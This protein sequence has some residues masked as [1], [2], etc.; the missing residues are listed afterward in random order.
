MKTAM[1]KFGKLA[2]VITLVLIVLLGGCWRQ[3]NR[4]SRNLSLEADN[5]NVARKLTVVNA[6]AED[7]NEAV[8]F[9]MMGNF[10]IN[11]DGDG[12]LNV[13][14]ENDDGTY[15]KHFVHLSRDITYV[16]EDM[17]TTGTN[18]YRY[19]INFNPRMIVPAEPVVID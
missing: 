6:R 13:V 8:L 9:Q 10:S 19:Q 1:N 12:D 15:Y 14:G 2:V 11:V 16:I 5:F 18:K 17:G 7:G 3:A 4:V